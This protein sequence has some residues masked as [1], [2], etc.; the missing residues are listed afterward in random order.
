MLFYA[1]FLVLYAY[2]MQSITIL[3][4][5]FDDLELEGTLHIIASHCAD[6]SALDMHISYT[7]LRENDIV[8]I[9]IL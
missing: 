5:K 2:C 3:V 4:S 7:Q 1:L 8:P 6:V 9:Q